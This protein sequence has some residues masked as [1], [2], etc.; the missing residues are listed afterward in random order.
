[1]QIDL[2]DLVG[3]DG[4]VLVG[5]QRGTAARDLFVLDSLDSGTDDVVIVAPDNLEAISPS[6]VQGF[7]AASLKHL[8]ED[9]LRAK[10]KFELNELLLGDIAGGIKRLQMKRKIAGLD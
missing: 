1:M 9:G 3:R 10:Y 7:L 8:G 5:M 4:V 6:F 2:T